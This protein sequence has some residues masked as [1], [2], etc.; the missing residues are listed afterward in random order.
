MPRNEIVGAREKVTVPFSHPT[1]PGEI[2]HEWMAGKQVSVA[3]T[4]SQL[5]VSSNELNLILTC[6]AL[7]P[8]TLAVRLKKIGWGNAQSWSGTQML[9]DIAQ[10][11]QQL[12]GPVKSTATVAS[13]AFRRRRPRI[14]VQDSRRVTVV[15]IPTRRTENL[16]S[17]DAIPF[18]DVGH[19]SIDV[20]TLGIRKTPI[21]LKHTPTG[22][23][24][25]PQR[26]SGH[27]VAATSN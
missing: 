9:W 20:S 6:E 4:A 2:L 19:L 16:C 1:H 5:D 14:A 25:S 21:H 23:F 26:R 12:G 10:A 3:D 22:P 15:G 7:L 24:Y 13:E 17:F 18:P 27:K 8:P 11:R